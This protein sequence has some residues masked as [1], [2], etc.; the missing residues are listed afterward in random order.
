MHETPPPDLEW[1]PLVPG[2]AAFRTHRLVVR[3]PTRIEL[4][5]SA[6][7]RTLIGVVVLVGV[8]A[9][10]IAAWGGVVHEPAAVVTAGVFVLTCAVLASLLHR[11]LD[12]RRCFDLALGCYWRARGSGEQPT[13]DALPLS[14]I[15]GLQITPEVVIGPEGDYAAYELNLVLEDG[16]RVNVLDHGNL[17]ALLADATEVASR[18]H[19]PLWIAPEL[20]ESAE[21]KALDAGRGPS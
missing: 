16:R 7:A 11:Q 6:Q 17:E 8:I 12:N 10:G 1:S 21:F 2:G 15:R 19:V 14:S 18:L 3:G 5:P 4:H 13:A 9:L 20:R